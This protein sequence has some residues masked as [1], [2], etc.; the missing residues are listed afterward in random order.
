MKTKFI[1]I[2]ACFIFFNSC[3]KDGDELV[4]RKEPLPFF[5]KVQMHSTFDVYLIQDTVFSIKFV[6]A[7]KMIDDLTYTITDS[8]LSISNDFNPKW[9]NPKISK[10]AVYISCNNIEQVT[11]NEACM[12]RTVNPITSPNF[13]LIAANKLNEADLELN[14]QTFY[15]WNNAPCGGK[16][17]LRGNCTNLK[18]WNFALMAVDAKNLTASYALVE[19]WAKADCHVK[20]IDKMEYSILGKG[21]IYLYSTPTELIE[22]QVTST[23]KLIM[24]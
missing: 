21:N 5:S 12:L 10:P 24:Q 8:T 19:N 3:K 6:G 15:Y 22:K 18:I 4:E 1:F 16:I 13:G 9:L 23:G 2:L 11:L 14:C 20:A 7:K 17:T